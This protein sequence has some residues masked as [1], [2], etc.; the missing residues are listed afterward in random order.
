MWV[1]SNS[2]SSNPR[3]NNAGDNMSKDIV[4]EIN[5]LICDTCKNK[6]QECENCYELSHYVPIQSTVCE[7]KNE[8]G[9]Y[10]KSAFTC[11]VES[12]KTYCGEFRRLK[13]VPNKGK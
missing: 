9:C 8:C 2:S 10:K 11:N 4:T 5:D 12:K 13:N 6:D 3:N 1:S 7:F